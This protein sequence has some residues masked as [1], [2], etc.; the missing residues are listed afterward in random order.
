VS[1][2]FKKRSSFHAMFQNFVLL[3]MLK[4]YIKDK[5]NDISIKKNYLDEIRFLTF[6]GLLQEALT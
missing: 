4:E 1:V 2:L 3:S 6:V 5:L